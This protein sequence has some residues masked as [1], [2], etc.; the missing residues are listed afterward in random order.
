MLSWSRGV[1]SPGEAGL[2][3]FHYVLEEM[4]SWRR[5]GF[6]PGSDD[7]VC[8]NIARLADDENVPLV[9]LFIAK[10]N[11][12]RGSNFVAFSSL[13]LAELGSIR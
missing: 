5:G 10:P 11:Q 1:Y 4:P 7:T 13:Y 12:G 6:S 3:G 8:K 9:R 2:D